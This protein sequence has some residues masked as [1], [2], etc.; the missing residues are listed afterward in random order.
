MKI[1]LD[2]CIDWRLKN[3]FTELEVSTVTDEGWLGK[4]NGEL[5]SLASQSGFDVFLTIDKKLRFS[6]E[7]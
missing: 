2:E 7:Y 3:D 1:L 6:T 4:K 5:L